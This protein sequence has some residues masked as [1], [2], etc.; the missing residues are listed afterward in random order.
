MFPKQYK[1]I[2][3]YFHKFDKLYDRNIFCFP[4]DNDYGLALL[5][6]PAD[7]RKNLIK[8]NYNKKETLKYLAKRIRLEVPKIVNASSDYTGLV[9]AEFEMRRWY[10]ADSI[11]HKG[12]C[13]PAFSSPGWL[14]EKRLFDILCDLFLYNLRKH[15]Y[16]TRTYAESV[17]ITISEPRR[18]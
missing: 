18:Q 4:N 12:P 5:S 13:G 1:K 11:H 6:L 7:I 8:H 9:G 15:E 2:R 16:D 17:Y 10:I 3:S 14:K